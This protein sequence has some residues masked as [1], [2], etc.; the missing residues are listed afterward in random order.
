MAAVTLT[1]STAAQAATYLRGMLNGL[2]KGSEGGA[3]ALEAASGK[4]EGM[5]ASYEDLRNIL[6]T[7]GIMA[8][9]EK[10]KQLQEEYGE[11]IVSKVFPNIRAMLEIFSLTGNNMQYN[12]ELIKR[13]T[14]SSGALGKAFNA[15]ADTV[16]IRYDRALTS[17]NISLI[18]LG[19]SVTTT[20]LPIIEKWIKR[21]DEMVKRFDSLTAAQKENR[22][23][24]VKWVALLGPL[25]MGL[26]VLIYTL[27][28]TMNIINGVGGAIKKL[29]VWFGALKVVTEGTTAKVTLFGKAISSKWSIAGKL[30]KNPYAL[31]VG[32]AIAAGVAINRYRKRAIEVASQNT[33]LDKTLVKVNGEFKK[34]RTLS[35]F[36]FGQMELPQ[37]QNHINWAT[38][39]VEQQL[40]RVKYFYNEAG[41]SAKEY[42]KAMNITKQGEPAVKGTLLW[43]DWQWAQK[44]L[45]VHGQYADQIKIE[46]ETLNTLEQQLV[47]SKKALEDY[48]KA[49]G[50]S[51]DVS[52]GDN[53]ANGLKNQSE[54]VKSIYQEMIEGIDAINKKELLKGDEF[55]KTKALYELYDS[56]IDKISEASD[57]SLNLPWVQKLIKDWQYLGKIVDIEESKIS[58]F[59]DNLNADLAS[60]K[61]RKSIEPSFDDINA[62]FE[63]YKE[64]YESYL[65]LAS[66]EGGKTS[67]FGPAAGVDIL[68]QIAL[69]KKAYTE[70]QKW[71]K[72]NED[73]E[74]A[75]LLNLLQA[76]AN[77]YGTLGSKIEVV[78][79]ML[80]AQEKAF[81]KA[82][83]PEGGGK[84][85]DPLSD[86][87]KKMASNINML[88]GTLVSLQNELDFRW[89]NDMNNALDN[90][91]TNSDLLSGYISALENQLAFLSETGQGST[92]MFKALA[93]EMQGYI[94][95]QSAVDTLAGAFTE[96]FD[97]L[98]EG[99]QNMGEVLGN[100]LK[101]ILRELAA[102]LAKMIAMKIIMSIINPGGAFMSNFGSILPNMQTG[103]FAKGG[104]VPSGYPGD[105]YPALLSSGEMVLPKGIAESI[106]KP[107]MMEGE[108]RFEIEGDRLVGI[109]RKQGKKNSIY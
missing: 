102:A 51:S 82:L 108:V 75:K 65:E 87:A 60:I 98:I 29:L 54:A 20:F 79:Y 26:S 35:S 3:E 22:L 24:L 41:V 21:F 96:L 59:V 49:S 88:K 106:S 62:T 45:K 78:N 13:V 103:R 86:E 89:L 42:D 64:N 38:N 94:T 15:V 16:K 69:I 37:L 53:L 27:T 25:T 8:L 47:D 63:A 85:L 7:G 5:A 23:Q 67:F 56:I 72:I 70:M 73:A 31:L 74:D 57:I 6:K 80:Q 105:T 50:K 101:G 81:K 2:M 46:T 95:A 9:M 90:F 18:N 71:E 12:N 48:I 52:T 83:Q 107:S 109:L 76:E 97:A 66:K 40:A 55:D 19:K 91:S 39:A 92:E 58:K 30:I 100:I 44:T 17:A 43:K 28:G 77:A 93:K 32:G 33:I 14:N 61:I 11:S 4:I 36:D 84:G 10:L 104:V 1:G 34:L 68:V 99:G